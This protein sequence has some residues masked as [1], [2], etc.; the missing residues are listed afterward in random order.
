MVALKYGLLPSKYNKYSCCPT[1]FV[2]YYQ[3]KSAIASRQSVNFTTFHAICKR[4]RWLRLWP[5]STGLQ[6]ERMK[7]CKINGTQILVGQQFLSAIVI[8][9]KSILFGQFNFAKSL[10][11]YLILRLN[12]KEK[13]I[14][15]I[16][17][18]LKLIWGA[19]FV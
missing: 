6:Q 14:I 18:Q 1:K 2:L 7:R 4:L 9:K 16:Q 12:F 3:F 8:T 17:F 5:A 19:L 10:N 13:K 11:S 15:F